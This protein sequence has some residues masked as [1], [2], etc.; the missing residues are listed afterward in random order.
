M[1]LF[2]HLWGKFIQIHSCSFL[3]YVSA[4]RDAQVSGKTFFLGVSVFSEKDGIWISRLSTEVSA[5][6]HKGIIQ[7]I[8]T[9]TETKQKSRNREISHSVLSWEKSLFCPQ[10]SVIMFLVLTHHWVPGLWAYIETTLSVSLGLAQV[11]GLFGL[12]VLRANLF[13]YVGTFCC[14]C[15]PRET[16]LRNATMASHHM[17]AFFLSVFYSW[18]V[19]VF[20]MINWNGYLFKNSVFFW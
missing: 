6:P 17:V 1:L 19:K 16:S 18:S 10:T 2:S 20:T 9:G 3:C 5:A 4:L 14:S 8:E 15:F 11:L 12:M 13:V 7:S